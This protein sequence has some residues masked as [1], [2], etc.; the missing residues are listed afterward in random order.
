MSTRYHQLILLAVASIVS[1]G[2]VARSQDGQYFEI[3]IEVLRPTGPVIPTCSAELERMQDHQKAGPVDLSLDGIFRFS[4]VPAGDYRLTIVDGRGSPLHQQTLT[5]DSRTSTIVV[6]LPIVM[7][8][9]ERPPSGTVSL[10]QLNHPPGKKALRAARASQK[11]FDAGDLE[12]AVGELTKAVQLSPDYAEAYSDLGALHI[13]LGLYE[14]AMAEIARALQIAGPNARDLSNRALAQYR[15]QRYAD[16]QQSAQSA[17][18]LAPEYAPAHYMLGIVLATDRRTL[19]EALP[20]LERAAKT[21]AAAGIS[22]M[23]VRK[24]LGIE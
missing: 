12:G 24:A 11:L 4:K 18:S 17:L 3:R 21:I 2:P 19:A 14:Q 7:E 16:A 10:R 20:H 22:L 6:R 5:I 23:A 8:S 1:A 9:V 15:L 13:K